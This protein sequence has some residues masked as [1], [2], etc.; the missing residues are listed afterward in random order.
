VKQLLT[1]DLIVTIDRSSS[2]ATASITLSS[3]DHPSAASVA[4]LIRQQVF[5]SS[6]MQPQIGSPFIWHD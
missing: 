2:G 4:E 5:R 3:S 6:G 1:A